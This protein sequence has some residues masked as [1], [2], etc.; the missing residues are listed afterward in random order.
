[1]RRS[2]N[3]GQGNR[4]KAEGAEV[5][6]KAAEHSSFA[7]LCPTSALH[8]VR[9]TQLVEDFSGHEKAQKGSKEKSLCC[10]CLF[11]AI[12]NVLV[13]ACRAVCFALKVVAEMMQMQG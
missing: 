8:S 3:Q 9:I 12:P 7:F 4:V 13:A 11:V 1:V 2:R 6:A 5:L 10:L